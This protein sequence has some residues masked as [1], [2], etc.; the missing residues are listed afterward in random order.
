MVLQTLADV[1]LR[2]YKIAPRNRGEKYWRDWASYSQRIEWCACFVSYCADQAGMLEA[3]NVKYSL[4]AS[5]KRFGLS[6]NIVLL[7]ET[8][9]PGYIVFFDNDDDDGLEHVGIVVEVDERSKMITVVEGNSNDK[10]MKKR[11][12]Y[13]TGYRSTI[14]SRAQIVCYGV[15]ET[16]AD[17]ME[18]AEEKMRHLIT[19]YIT[20]DNIQETNDSQNGKKIIVSINNDFDYA[21]IKVQVWT[22]A[23]RMDALE[24]LTLEQSKGDENTYVGNFYTKNH[25]DENGEYK[26]KV[27]LVDEQGW[28][29]DGIAAEATLY[30]YSNSEG[31]K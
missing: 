18:E 30:M 3:G 7:G 19:L 5:P 27:N 22:S 9:K 26:I 17:T 31:K 4:V 2:E 16:M 20:D 13:E 1:A 10:L 12:N 8:P 29:I 15:P 21:G 14:P 25:N 24:M 28:I 6:K 23:N 11:Y